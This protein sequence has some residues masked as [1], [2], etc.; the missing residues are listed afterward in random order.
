MTRIVP[1]QDMKVTGLLNTITD[2]QIRTARFTVFATLQQNY[3]SLAIRYTESVLL[4]ARH[5][6][7]RNRTYDA[8]KR[9]FGQTLKVK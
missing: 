2:N 6:P 8:K 4:T 7:V 3:L 5:L 1:N 9:V